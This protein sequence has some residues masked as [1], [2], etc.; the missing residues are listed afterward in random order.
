MLKDPLAERLR[1]R[2]KALMTEAQLEQKDVVYRSGARVDQVQKFL[3]G[4]LQF[5]PLTFL[6]QVFAIFDLSLVDVLTGVPTPKTPL[7]SMRPDVVRVALELGKLPEEYVELQRQ[8]ALVALKMKGTGPALATPP[9]P[10]PAAL[11]T[12]ATPPSPHRSRKR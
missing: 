10:R 4:Q 1:Q 12:T 9:A 3:G 7:Q 2:L 8:Q 5:P 11:D 6:Q